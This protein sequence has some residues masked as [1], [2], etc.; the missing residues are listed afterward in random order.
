MRSPRGEEEYCENCGRPM[1]LKKGRFG[2][3]YA[4]SGYPDC[5]TTK[6]T[7]R[8]QQKKADVPLEE[9]CP[10]CGKN[11]V[12]RVRPLRRVRRLL[13][14]SEVQVRQAEDHRREVPEL[15]GRRDRGAQLKARQVLRLQSLSGVRLYDWGKPMPNMPA[16]RQSL[17]GREVAEG[18]SGRAVPE[19]GVQIQARLPKPEPEAELAGKT[20]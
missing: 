4:C 12:Q 17:S 10:N 18:R 7:R 5:K 16:V 13:R 15:L 11:L 20:A 19:S 1:V 3:F 9:T 2:Q 6:Q 14:L 8:Q